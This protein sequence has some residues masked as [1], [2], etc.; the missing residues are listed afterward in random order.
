MNRLLNL[1]FILIG[2]LILLT[3]SGCRSYVNWLKENAI[4]DIVLV[5]PD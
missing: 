4:E 1:L 5:N 2:I 3:N